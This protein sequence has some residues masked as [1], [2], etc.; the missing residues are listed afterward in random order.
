MLNDEL[1]KVGGGAMRFFVV[2]NDISALKSC[3]RVGAGNRVLFIN[4]F[5]PD[6]IE[7]RQPK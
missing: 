3:L 7:R 2:Q 6:V 4:G 1:E 5:V